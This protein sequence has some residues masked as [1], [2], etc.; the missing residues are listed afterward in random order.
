GR[1]ADPAGR[2]GTV[3]LKEIVVTATQ[4]VEPVQSVPF[5]VTAMTA[6]DLTRIDAHNLGDFAAYVPGLIT[7]SGAAPGLIVIRGVTMG[8]GGQLSSAIGLYLDGVPLG[9]STSF[10]LGYQSFNVNTFDLDRVEVLN[11]PQGTLYGADSLGGAVRYET[12]PPDP[13]TLH[14]VAETEISHTEH[15]GTNYGLRG[16]VNLPFGAGLGALRIDA[17]DN[18]DSGYMRNPVYHRDNQ[19]ATRNE[20][21]RVQLLLTPV[22]DLDIRLGVF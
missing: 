15:G 11:G 7:N 16:M 14:A 13:H 21:G 6:H 19:G 10:G 4:R 3:K 12:A 8:T 5:Q 18:H 22:S 1:Q 17:I 2:A 9:A 20:G